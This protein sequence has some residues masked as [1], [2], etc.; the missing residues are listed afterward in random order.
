MGM[1]RGL[2]NALIK[3][4]TGSHWEVFLPSSLAFGDRGYRGVEPGATVIYDVQL[5][6]IDVPAAPAAA[7]PLTSDIIRVPSAEELK[8]GR[9]VE[10]LKPED[11]ARMQAT[12]GAAPAKQ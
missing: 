9:K 8:A 7:P 5:Q 2:A 12:N 3:M 10:V 11:V 1:V 6:S 4:K